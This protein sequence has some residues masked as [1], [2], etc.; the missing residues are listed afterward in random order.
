MA[1]LPFFF[2][3]LG[4]DQKQR[5]IVEAQLHK[6]RAGNTRCSYC[7]QNR[8]LTFHVAEKKADLKVILYSTTYTREREKKPF[9]LENKKLS[10]KSPYLCTYM[11]LEAYITSL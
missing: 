3:T 7:Y 6:S 5:I 1:Y 8:Q 9:A 10:V 4:N 11:I 2:F